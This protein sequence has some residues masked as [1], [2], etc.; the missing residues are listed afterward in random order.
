MSESDKEKTAVAVPRGKFEFNVMPFGLSNSGATYQRM[1][2][3][4]LSGLRTDKVLS[5]MDDI[6]IFSKTFDE[7]IRDLKSVFECLHTA[8]VT[9]KA[10]KCIFAA[11]KVEFL[12]FELSVEGI[13]PQ[14]RL[15]N[16]INDLPRPGSKKELRRFLGMAGFYRAFIKNFTALSQPLNRLTGDNVPFVWDSRCDSAFQKIKQYLSCKPVLAFP[17][18]NEP[19]VVECD[20]NDYAAGR[21]LSQKGVDN[22][23][24]PIAYFSTSFTGFQRNWA[25]ITKEAFALVLAVRHWQIYLIGAEFILRSDHNP[26]VYIRKQKDPRGKFGRWI[27]ELEEYHYTVEHIP[28]KDNF[29]AD[30]LIRLHMNSNHNHLLRTKYMLR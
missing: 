14:A 12:G 7:H 11:E 25:P 29:K 13:K 23:L 22:V 1:M 19:F 9:L 2:D 8:D 21:V 26:L 30:F 5:Y 27:A 18:L 28:G 10:S 15:T 6:V 4:C 20:A 16:A 17:K 3:I 24:H